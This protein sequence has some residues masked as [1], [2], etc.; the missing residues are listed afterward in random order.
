M[1]QAKILDAYVNLFVYTV[2]LKGQE[3]WENHVPHCQWTLT[4][5]VKRGEQSEPI[6]EF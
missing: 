1:T 5:G 3:T 2:W 4:L 6:L